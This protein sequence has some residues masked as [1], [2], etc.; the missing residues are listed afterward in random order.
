[1]GTKITGV[2]NNRIEKFCEFETNRDKDN[3]NFNDNPNDNPE[4]AKVG[5]NE[6]FE[7]FENSRASNWQK[8]DTAEKIHKRLGEL[9][10][11][12]DMELSKLGN[13]ISLNEFETKLHPK[14][15]EINKKHQAFL[16]SQDEIFHNK[17]N[18]Y[19][20]PLCLKDQTTYKGQWSVDGKRNGFGMYIKPNGGLYIGFWENDKMCGRGRFIDPKGNIYEGNFLD[21]CA[22]GYGIYLK[23]DGTKYMGYWKNDLQEGEGTE[24]YSDGSASYTGEFKN[25]EK[26]GHG[27]FIWEDKSKYV[28][29]F[30]NNVING[31]GTY[32]W[33]DGREY[34][35][36][37]ENGKMH[38]KGI[39]SWPDGKKYE[40]DYFNDK[41]EGFGKYYWNADKYY[42]GQWLNGVR[43]GE[44]TLYQNG[45]FYKGIWEN[46]KM[47]KNEKSKNVKNENLSKI[48]EDDNILPRK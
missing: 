12:I 3:N 4:R 36:Q 34:I 44:G 2:C 33:N 39:F 41:K 9:H 25:G 31:I 28:G 38:G 29:Q 18:F 6:R 1:M 40:G 19:K 23:E 7:T 42:E 15:I 46:G 17:L 35:G 45:K 21:G 11:K 48:S 30:K 22:S 43:H 27:T 14:I 13:F 10:E 32:Y 24:Y 37:W 5:K 20:K 16:P 47:V 8:Y 26:N